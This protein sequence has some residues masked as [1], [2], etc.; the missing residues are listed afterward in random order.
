MLVA[1]LWGCTWW[2]GGQEGAMVLDPLSAGFQSLPLLPTIRWAPSGAVSRVGG[3]V[4]ALGPCGSLQRPLLWGWEFLL[5]PPQ[6]PRVFSI[7]GLRLYFPALEPWVI[8]SASSSAACPVLSTICQ[9]LCPAQATQ[10]LSAQAA[11]LC[12]SFQSGWTSLFYLLGCWTSIQFDFL[13][14][15]FFCF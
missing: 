2:E 3:L 10:V 11:S 14:V 15:L 13:S 7:R 12:P 1:A 5:L 9:S 4:H 6:P 8:V